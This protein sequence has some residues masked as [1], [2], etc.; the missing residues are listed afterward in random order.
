MENLGGPPAPDELE[1]SVFGPGFG[2]AIAIHIG[3]GAWLTVDSCLD[4]ATGKPAALAWLEAMQVPPT[5]I[6]LVVITHWHDDHIRGVSKLYAAASAAQLCFPEAL[7]QREF[8]TFTG[9]YSAQRTVPGSSGVDELAEALRIFKERAGMHPALIGK[10]RRVLRVE[11]GDLAHGQA[12]EVWSLSPSDK[13][14]AEFL[15][16]IIAQSPILGKA[17]R[18]ATVEYPNHL[19]A[20]LLIKAANEA[21]LLGAD[22]ENHP[23]PD[24]GWNSVLSSQGRPR[25]LSFFFKVPHHGSENAHH[26]EVWKQMLLRNPISII[27]PYSRLKEPLPTEAD[28]KRIAAHTKRAFVTAQVRRSPFR[29]TDPA[30]QRTLREMPSVKVFTTRTTHGSITVRWRIG[31][32]PRIFTAGSSYG[33]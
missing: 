12:C 27:T 16:Q 32:R 17:K 33:L 14:K 4:P 2:E 9:A 8:L 13:Q 22:L 29:A 28:K 24:L 11:P 1:V 21:V 15:A 5:A 3:S 19:S 31:Q 20:V 18:R 26:D 23:D 25:L 7:T 6:R 30:V 10:D